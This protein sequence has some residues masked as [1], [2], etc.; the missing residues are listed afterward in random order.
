MYKISIYDVAGKV[1]ILKLVT[2]SRSLARSAALL[3][4]ENK[5]KV[6]V[7]AEVEPRTVKFKG[8]A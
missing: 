8:V 1:A 2:K 3:G 7:V 4:E 6:E 5:L